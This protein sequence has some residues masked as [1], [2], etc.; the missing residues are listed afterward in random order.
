MQPCNRIYYS[1]VYWRL[2]TFRA[3]Y[4]SSQGAPNCICSLWF[5]YTYGDW[6]L[7]RLIGNS[8][9]TTAGH[10]MCILTRGCKYSLE[11][12]VMSGMPLKMCWAFSKLWNNKFYY[13]VASCWLFLLNHTT[14]HRSMNIKS[15]FWLRKFE[16]W[17]NICLAEATS[18]YLVI[19]TVYIPWL[20]LLHC[21]DSEGM[22]VI[23]G[24]C[25]TMHWN[26]S[27]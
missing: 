11:L 5:I 21:S 23:L 6:P 17:V 27:L 15:V 2:N 13:K 20:V 25:L 4:R 16:G 7:S 19:E 1:K 22:T 3:A 26:V 8:A 9:W 10:H 18:R 24:T 12:L 14:M